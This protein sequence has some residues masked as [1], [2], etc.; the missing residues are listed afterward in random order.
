MKAVNF[1][2]AGDS[3]FITCLLSHLQGSGF[4]LQK[5][6]KIRNN[7]FYI[8][9]NG[10]RKFIAKGF[11]SEKKLLLQSRLINL[12]KN[13][14]FDKTYSINVDLPPMQ[15]GGLHYAFLEYLMPHPNPFIFLG[16]SER[17]EGLQ[18]LG[19]FHVASSRISDDFHLDLSSFDQTGK[20]SE[21]FRRFQHN[22]PMVRNYVSDHVLEQWQKWADWSLEGLTRNISWLTHEKMAI[23]HGDVANH[24][25][26]R[27]ITGELCLIDFDLI[28]IAPPV[29]DYLQY[30]NRIL[31][32]VSKPDEIW[33]YPELAPYKRNPAFLYALAF[34]ADIFREW[35]RLAKEQKEA[36]QP[37]LHAIWKMT[38]EQFIN[39]MHFNRHL[40]QLILSLK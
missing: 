7:I 36:R 37:Q 13:N 35:N 15:V 4:S 31:P 30:A 14:G 12:L 20:W 26:L 17:Q 34:P 16:K 11:S 32:Y 23:I 22:L 28:S 18:L 24:N 8:E 39:R 6:A 40:E 38:V 19:Q 5:A 29:I 1:K 21:R 27:K 33:E 2:T 9:T 25:F 3:E 10:F